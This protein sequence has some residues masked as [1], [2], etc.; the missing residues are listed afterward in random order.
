MEANLIMRTL[1]ESLLKRKTGEKPVKMNL[2]KRYVNSVGR[3]HKNMFISISNLLHKYLSWSRDG[4]DVS[5]NTKLDGFGTA[6]PYPL[7]LPLLLYA[8]INGNS[9]AK[10]RRNDKTRLNVKSNVYRSHAAALQIFHGAYLSDRFV[11]RCCNSLG[12]P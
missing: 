3:A 12:L 4:A 5:D 9:R 2:R 6:V 10:A 11:P 1:R 7:P 8:S